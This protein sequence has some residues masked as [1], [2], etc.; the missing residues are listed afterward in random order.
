MCCR[1]TLTVMQAR[2][3][4]RLLTDTLKAVGSD[5]GIRRQ[6]RQ[7]SA[8]PT[9]TPT[10]PSITATATGDFETHQAGQTVA[11]AAIPQCPPLVYVIGR[12]KPVKMADPTCSVAG[13]AKFQAGLL[14]QAAARKLRATYCAIAV[15][16]FNTTGE[17]RPA[18]QPDGV[19][20]VVM[21]AHNTYK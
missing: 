21:L 20:Q 2:L 19:A 11:N 15:Y 5:G 7:Q 16:P 17:P 3:E 1:S 8:E 13:A 12:N 4:V 18:G 6:L 14:A 10:T 9:A